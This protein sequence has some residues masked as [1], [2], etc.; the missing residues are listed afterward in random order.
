MASSTGGSSDWHYS[1]QPS[2][3]DYYDRLWL[4]ASPSGG[5]LSGLQAVN[6]FKKSEVDINILKQIWGF[7]SPVSTMN[8]AQF[9]CACR[10]IAIYQNGDT[11]L[12]KEMLKESASAMLDLPKF[13]GLVIPPLPTVSSTYP[14]IS[15]EIHMRY[16]ELFRTI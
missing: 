1:P 6:F 4:V 3:R 2:E 12:R 7:S 14:P 16:H 9:Y 5:E 8:R 15:A 13:P 10:Y 11:S